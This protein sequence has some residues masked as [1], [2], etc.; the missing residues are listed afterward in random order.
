ME[1]LTWVRVR[2]RVRVRGWRCSAGRGQGG[3]E[4]WGQARAGWAG[5]WG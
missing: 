4:G 2:V 1:V 3:R 5:E